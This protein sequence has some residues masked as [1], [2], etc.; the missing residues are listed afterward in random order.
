MHDFKY[1]THI[2]ILIQDMF[3]NY[4]TYI[5]W[6]SHTSLKYTY[7]LNAMTLFRPQFIFWIDYVSFSNSLK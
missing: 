1:I 2:F 7:V 4:K 5:Q 6:K 3:M